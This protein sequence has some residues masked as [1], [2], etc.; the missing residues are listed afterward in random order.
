MITFKEYMKK[1]LQDDINDKDLYHLA[2]DIENDKDFPNTDN[3]E[4]IL[5]YLHNKG[6]CKEFLLIALDELCCYKYLQELELI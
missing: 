3:F 6:T 1:H 2:Y 5:R 4:I